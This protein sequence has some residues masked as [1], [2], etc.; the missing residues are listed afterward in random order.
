MALAVP[1]QWRYA[2]INGPTPEIPIVTDKHLRLAACLYEGTLADFTH[3]LVQLAKEYLRKSELPQDDPQ[4]LTLKASMSK[5]IED[6]ENGEQFVIDIIFSIHPLVLEALL[7][8][9]FGHEYHTNPQFKGLLYP[10]SYS[11]GIY[12]NTILVD[13]PYL[14]GAGPTVLEWKTITDAMDKYAWLHITIFLLC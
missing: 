6:Y 2:H 11:F 14:G 7:W 3:E 12:I 4:K 8:N 1:I 5:I 13:D 10:I 9:T